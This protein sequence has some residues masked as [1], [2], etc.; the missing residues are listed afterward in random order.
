M[1][2]LF[3]TEEL[4]NFVQRSCYFVLIFRTKSVSRTKSSL[5][6]A[7]VDK[8]QLNTSKLLLDIV[9]NIESS[10]LNDMKQLM[11]KPIQM[12]GRPALDEVHFD[13]CLFY[14][15]TYGT[16]V[17]LVNFY[18][19]HGLWQKAAKFILDMVSVNSSFSNFSVNF[20]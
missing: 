1:S 18:R 19:R 5:F 7:P 11:K 6:Q 8:N 12:D 9:E 3:N 14:L 13:E 4:P 17:S 16:Y 10:M 20:N 15:K 2:P